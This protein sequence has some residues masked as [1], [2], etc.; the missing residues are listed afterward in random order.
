MA[1]VAE[2]PRASVP[3]AS[4]SARPW[5]RGRVAMGAEG[6]VGGMAPPKLPK[7]AFRPKQSLG[8]CFL[9]DANYIDRIVDRFTELVREKGQTG[10]NGM[11]F[12][13][14]LG[15]GLGAITQ[16]V[17]GSFPSMAAVE[18][19]PRAVAVLRQSMPT[20]DVFEQDLL[21]VDYTGL[22]ASRGCRMNIIANLPYMIT[23]DALLA[24]AAHAGAI[25]FAYVMVQKEVADKVVAQPG[26]KEYGVLAAVLQSCARPRKT[27]QLP[28]TAF[29]PAPKVTSAMLEIEFKDLEE[30]P[31]VD[32]AC[33]LE[34]VRVCFQQRGKLLK[35]SLK[36]LIEKE[37]GVI[38]KQLEKMTAETL[39]PKD[40]EE[41][42]RALLPRSSKV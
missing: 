5:R 41:I 35:H 4:A 40:F 25:R 29:Y 26:S 32:G 15:P 18:I 1:F 9:Q 8:Q 16:R 6:A 22:A 24:L 2:P 19:D 3:I 21:T 36:G 13:V 33:L 38:P 34:V 28:G 7:G 23:T 31:K 12:V 17:H 10:A 20:L 42:T 27:F 39:K 14:E 11:P 37:R 30:L